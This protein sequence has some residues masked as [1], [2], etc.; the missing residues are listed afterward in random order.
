MRD[1]SR[2]L[3][4]AALEN[5][6]RRLAALYRFVDSLCGSRNGVGNYTEEEMPFSEVDDNPQKRHHAV[7][8]RPHSESMGKFG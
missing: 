2:E 1:D 4:I 5:L 8:I 3:L 7:R 6:G